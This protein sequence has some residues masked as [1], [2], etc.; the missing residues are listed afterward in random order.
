MKVTS[1]SEG[2]Q[3][4]PTLATPWAA[5]FQAPPSMGFSRQN[6]WS[7]VP[8]NTALFFLIVLSVECVSLDAL[9]SFHIHHGFF[10]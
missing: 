1:E 4:C 3:L 10:F 6:Y 5:A 9:I 2:A 8:L 7:G